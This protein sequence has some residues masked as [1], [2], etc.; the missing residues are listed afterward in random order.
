MSSN[1]KFGYLANVIPS[2]TKTNFLLF[3]A[4]AGELTEAKIIVSHKNPYPTK[5]RIA[6]A[7]AS[8]SNTPSTLKDEY[9]YYNSFVD[10]GSTFSTDLI[11]VA[12]GQK[13]F[14][15]SDREDTNFILEGITSPLPSV[16]SGVLATQNMPSLVKSNHVLYSTG[17]DDEA[18]IILYAVN[19]GTETARLR[20][21]VVDQGQS[22]SPAGYYDYNVRVQAGQTYIRK[23]LRL[24]ENQDLVVRT[25]YGELNFVAL[26]T[27]N[28][29]VAAQTSLTL[30]GNL[31]IGG[32]SNFNSTSTFNSNILIN[33][34]TI[35]GYDVGGNITY[36]LDPANGTLDAS[37]ITL[38]NN[39]DITGA[40]N[41]NNVFTVDPATGNVTISGI[42]TAGSIDFDLSIDGDLDLL[43]N[44]VINVANPVLAQHAS[45]KAYTDTTAVSYAIALS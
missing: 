11:Y 3:T 37:S 21:G 2:A 41:V 26:G 42:L 23:T 5:I 14:V 35:S 1:P 32:S 16:G 45:T 7:S 25:D 40:L 31:S 34:G 38:S 36:T 6:V 15:W 27:F 43:N 9:I 19:R 24:H 18:T 44:K 13:V 12:D 22:I 10:E 33:G 30:P 28:F 17:S 29:E 4:D 39:L 8:T 20:V